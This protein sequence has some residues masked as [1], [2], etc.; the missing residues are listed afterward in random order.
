MTNSADDQHLDRVLD[1]FA[2]EFGLSR[3]RIRRIIAD[4]HRTLEE[5]P[6]VDS[7]PVIVEHEAWLSVTELCF[8]DARAY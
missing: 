2:A 6:L 3:R 4:A 8:D 1:R 7:V 5:A